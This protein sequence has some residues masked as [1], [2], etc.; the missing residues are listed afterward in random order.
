MRLFSGLFLLLA[1]QALLVTAIPAAALIF[2]LNFLFEHYRD[3]RQSMGPAADAEFA[4]QQIIAVIAVLMA[5]LGLMLAFAWIVAVRWTRPQTALYRASTAIAEGN[6]G[7]TFAEIGPIETQVT[8]RNLGRIAR[9]FDRLENARR[10][11][12]VAIAE[13]LRKP[14]AVLGDQLRAA[15]DMGG[16]IPDDSFEAVDDNVQRLVEITADLQAVALADLGRLPVTFA[17]VDPCALIHNA[18][19]SNKRRAQLAKVVLEPGEMPSTTVLVKW[20]GARIEQLFT[21][22]IE[23]SLRY[24]PPGGRIRLGLEQ[25]RNAWRLVIDDSAP[26]IDVD[27]AQRLF[28][29]FY[30]ATVAP[31]ESVTSSGLGLATAQ[32]IVEAHHG[33]IEAGTSP[34]GGL[35]VYVILPTIPPTA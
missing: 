25:R 24:T 8:I 34:M 15:R 16:K 11:W 6:F 33:R 3:L 21:A 5:M 18:I 19:W 9:S 20:D 23:N 12:L 7:E 28:E 29:P 10:T 22:L 30:R 17:Q 1:A 26:G 2:L 14:V 4:R 32:A 35:R 31:G 27:L 13:E